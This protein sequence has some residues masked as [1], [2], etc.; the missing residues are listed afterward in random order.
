[1]GDIFGIVY[2]IRNIINNKVYIGQTTRKLNKRIHEYKQAYNKNILYNQ[3]LLNAL[4]KYSWEN[5]E[6]LIID[7][8]NNIDELNKK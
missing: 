3:Y 6:F 2:V 8:A 7:T 4:K 1:M 5:F